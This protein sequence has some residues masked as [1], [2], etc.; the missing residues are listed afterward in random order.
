MVRRGWASRGS[1]RFSL[2]G[3]SE[4]R[5]QPEAVQ[6]GGASWGVADEFEGGDGLFDGE[7]DLVQ[8][9]VGVRAVVEGQVWRDV[10][11]GAA[12]GRV[13][14]EL[15]AHRGGEVAPRLG[16]FGH[17]MNEPVSLEAVKTGKAD[18]EGRGCG[19]HSLDSAHH[20]A[21]QVFL[22]DEGRQHRDVRMNGSRVG[23]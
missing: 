9:G 18:A 6:D 14:G 2:T 12:V 16:G 7:V 4:G 17:R 10:T 13:S 3:V 8:Q 23:A 1:G 5:P 19:A 21:G 11:E 20:V 22:A 15:P